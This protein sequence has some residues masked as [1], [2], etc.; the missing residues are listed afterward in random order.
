[1]DAKKKARILASDHSSKKKQLFRGTYIGIYMRYL[2]YI[3]C[4]FSSEIYK[5]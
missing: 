3:K 5:R 4:D 2:Y 1:M